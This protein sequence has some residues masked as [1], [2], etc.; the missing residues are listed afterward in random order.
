MKVRAFFIVGHYF[1]RDKIQ[2]GGPTNLHRNRPR[3]G[4]FHENHLQCGGK[5]IDRPAP[6]DGARAGD[7]PQDGGSQCGVVE[8]AAAA[9]AGGFSE[10]DSLFGGWPAFGRHVFAC[11]RTHPDCR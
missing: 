10:I 6:D 5:S 7:D 1:E 8:S 11:L 3:G 4:G 2:L 9:G